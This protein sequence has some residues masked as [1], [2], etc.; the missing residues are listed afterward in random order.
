MKLKF[1]LANFTSAL[2]LALA[3]GGTVATVAPQTSPMINAVGGAL[4]GV[5]GLWGQFN[6]ALHPPGTG[7]VSAAPAADPGTVA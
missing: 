3:I 1:T 5:A 2:R 7:I 4:I 6:A